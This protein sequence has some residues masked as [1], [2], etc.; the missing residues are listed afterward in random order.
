M[1][2]F[3]RYADA[4]KQNPAGGVAYGEGF[5]ISWQD[6][7]VVDG[8]WS[9]AGV[10]E[11]LEAVIKRFEFFEATK[12]ACDEN[13]KVIALIKEAIRVIDARTERRKLLGIEGTYKTAADEEE[14]DHDNT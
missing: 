7:A 9:G 8:E 5:C 13:K 12:F 4:E 1:K 14:A 3:N 6:G 10:R 2:V 11:I